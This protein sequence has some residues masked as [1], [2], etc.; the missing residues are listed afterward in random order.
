MLEDAP[1]LDM[2]VVPVGGGGL[3][4]GMAIAVRALSGAMKVI[5]AEAALYPSFHNAIRGEGCPSAARRW[6]RASR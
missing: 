6:R 1:G 3:I 2:I 4:S 5:G